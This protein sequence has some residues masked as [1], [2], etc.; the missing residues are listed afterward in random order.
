MSLTLRTEVLAA[1]LDCRPHGCGRQAYKD[2]F[3]ACRDML[4]A[5]VCLAHQVT[6]ISAQ[7]FR[8]GRASQVLQLQAADSAVAA[9]RRLRVNSNQITVKFITPNPA[10]I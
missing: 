6:W 10:P 5:L 4:Q 2:V 1:W 7:V 3:T 8:T 9:K